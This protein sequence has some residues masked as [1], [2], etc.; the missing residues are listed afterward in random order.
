MS[1]IAPGV[2]L[3]TRLVTLVAIERLQLHKLALQQR[4]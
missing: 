1:S 4:V 3:V 2:A